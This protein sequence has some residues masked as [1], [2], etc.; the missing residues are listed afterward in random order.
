MSCS[1]TA[2]P[3]TNYLETTSPPFWD[4]DWRIPL[5]WLG[6]MA[7][8]LEKRHQRREL[9]MLDDRMLADI[10]VSRP[11]AVDEALKSLRL[12]VRSLP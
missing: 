11:Q 7:L 10:G 9:L 8:A 2:C 6:R 5:G 12:T 3:S 4:L 1:S